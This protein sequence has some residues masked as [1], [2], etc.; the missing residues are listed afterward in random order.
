M[1]RRT[2]LIVANWKM[3]SVPQGWDGEDSAYRARPGVD[4]VVLPTFVDIRTCLEKFL[5][6]GAQY[7]RPEPFGAFT[8]DVSMQILAA[9]GCTFVLCGHSERRLY[10]GET[11]AFVAEQVRSAHAA[12]LTPIVCVGEKSQERDNG[13]A[14]S[15]IERQVRAIPL[16]AVFAYEPLWAI[17]TGNAA[18]SV[19]AQEMHAFTRGL[20]PDEVQATTRIL[21]GGSVKPG[22]A[23]AFLGESDIDG[24]LVGGASLDPKSFRAIVEAA[25]GIK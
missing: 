24:L 15:I 7:G 2:P 4:V 23:P 8:G 6:V 9:H 18:T 12:G 17:G 14:R 13:Q 16:P 3:H 5:V 22:N 1:P 25:Q 21:Y 10:H 20:L 19:Q 11:D